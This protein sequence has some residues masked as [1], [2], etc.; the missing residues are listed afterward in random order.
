L[1]PL[2]LRRH[3]RRGMTDGAVGS[4][5]EIALYQTPDGELRL[6]VQLDEETVWLTQAQM[7]EL[8]GRERSVI[9]KHLG[10]VFREGE[11][12]KESNVQNLHIASSD[13]PVALYNLD[14]VISVGYRVKSK[15]GTD[16]RIWATRTLREHLVR[17]YT[18]NEWRLREK[19]LTEMEQAM[20]LLA[21]TL[22]RNDLVTGEGR[23]VLDVVQ[24]YARTWRLLLAYDEN[25]LPA[26]PLGTRRPSKD[27]SLHDAR[28]AIVRLRTQL[29]TG[30]ETVALFG[31]ERGEQL[32]GLLAAIEQTFGGEPLYPS[33]E[34]RAAHLLYFVIKDHPFSDGNK[35]IACLLFLDYLGSNGALLRSDG[36]PRFADNTLVALAL[37]IAESD[38][39]QKDLM[40]RLTINL[41]VEEGGP[42]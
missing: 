42:T 3:R 41:L 34:A 11:L 14:V 23:A 9:T 16:F 18:L 1:P 7:A 40:V 12:A 6:E 10:N 37:L 26:A 22:E 32:E 35:R 5:G 29:A 21:R 27:L 13:R 33:V 39:A 20:G 36:A 28:A 38:P 2:L 31:R 17:G 4:R 30:D 24:H 25:R 19:G 15:R 8:F